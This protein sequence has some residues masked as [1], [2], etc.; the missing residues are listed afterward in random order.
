MLDVQVLEGTRG[1]WSWGFVKKIPKGMQLPTVLY[2]ALH[3]MD[4]AQN[5]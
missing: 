4:F 1:F 2:S 5:C 3:L